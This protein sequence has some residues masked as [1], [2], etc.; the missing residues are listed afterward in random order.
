MNRE[1]VEG[2][3]LDL[4]RQNMEYRRIIRAS[5]DAIK[6]LEDNENKLKELFKQ[7]D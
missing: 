7:L 6:Y 5:Q 2:K 3:M 4:I 1:E